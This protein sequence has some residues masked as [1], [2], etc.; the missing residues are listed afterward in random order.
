LLAA[1]GSTVGWVGF[2]E[3]PPDTASVFTAQAARQAEPSA[4]DRG[5]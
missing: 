4:Q 3:P 5:C 2:E 1:T